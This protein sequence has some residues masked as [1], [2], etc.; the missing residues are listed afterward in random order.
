VSN[1]LTGVII[2]LSQSINAWCLCFFFSFMPF[3]C[4]YHTKFWLIQPA[5]SDLFAT[6][7]E[8][9]TP[10]LEITRIK[11]ILTIVFSVMFAIRVGQGN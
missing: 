10:V 5:L 3:S 9:A 11:D 6:T 1:L 2:D 7:E 8:S 4:F